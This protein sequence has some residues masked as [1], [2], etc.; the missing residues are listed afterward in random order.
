MGATLP[1]RL[2]ALRKGDLT[3]AVAQGAQHVK[4]TPAGHFVLRLEIACQ[5]ETIRRVSELF[6]D[7]KPDLFI[8][9]MTLRDG[10]TC[11]Q[12]LYGNFSGKDAAEKEIKRLPPAFQGERNRPKVFRF[13]EIPKE[14]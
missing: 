13:S 10:R 2:E 7:G 1:E 11:Y 4:E 3:R 12:V 9:P 8:L 5:G 6:K 14:Q